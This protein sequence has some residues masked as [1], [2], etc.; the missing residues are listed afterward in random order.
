MAEAA[1]SL[2]LAVV[3]VAVVVVE[4]AA[5][6]LQRALLL[7]PQLAQPEVRQ[8]HLH[9]HAKLAPRQA[10]LHEPAPSVLPQVLLC[11]PALREP[12]ERQPALAHPKCDLRWI[13][14]RVTL[15]RGFVAAP[16]S[17]PA[18]LTAQA[19]ALPYS[20]LQWATQ[21]VLAPLQGLAQ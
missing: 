9:A 5:G 12:L 20:V 19:E 14:C 17:W 10:H 8:V 16:L 4:A 15:S 3:A 6:A 7:L 21:P 11:V 13:P 18:L 1:I 2:Q